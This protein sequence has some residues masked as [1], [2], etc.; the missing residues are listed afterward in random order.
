MAKL[1]RMLGWL[2]V[3][4]LGASAWPGLAAAQQ[5][6]AA[7]APTAAGA[8][9]V[10]TV[11]VTGANRGL[12]LAWARKYAERGWNVIATV[13]E[14]GRAGELRALVRAGAPIRI[15]TLDATDPKSIDAFVKRLGGQ[16]VD[17][18]VNN[19]GTIGEEPE[20]KL[21]QLDP[22][23]FDH[24][25]R[26]NA[27][28]ALLVTERLLPNLRAGKQ[29]KVA[30]ISAR[31]ASFAA[32]PRIHSGLYYYKAS[33]AALNMV[34]RNLAMDLQGDGIAV[35]ALSPG[36]V[37]TYGTPD[38]HDAMSPE[39]RASMTDVDTSVAG[40]MKVMDGLTL[41]GS[42]RWYR[43]TGDVISW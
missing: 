14:P 10:P 42:G 34:L 17:V 25:M 2:L 7:R 9:A 1:R 35:A 38:D 22:S 33:K 29:K 27:L 19:A 3:F 32:Y 15:E 40:M 21:G 8:G 26:V 39:M 37:N 24:Y 43:Y 4:G 12:G 36:V 30:G 6:G 41:E 20:Q 5:S 23:R 13:R 16:P 31:V 11:V 18:L 28:S